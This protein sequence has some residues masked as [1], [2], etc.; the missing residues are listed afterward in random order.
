MIQGS[1]DIYT[2]DKYS[3]GSTMCIEECGLTFNSENSE[4]SGELEVSK[5]CFGDSMLCPPE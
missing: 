5:W 1:G 3:W 2:F 4:F